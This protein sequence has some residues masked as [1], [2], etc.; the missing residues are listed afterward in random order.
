LGITCLCSNITCCV[1]FDVGNI[2][3]YKFVF[4]L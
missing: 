2:R 3:N 1:Q 4:M